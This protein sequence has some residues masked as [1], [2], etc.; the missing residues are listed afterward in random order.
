ME[1]GFFSFLLLF[2]FLSYQKQTAIMNFVECTFFAFLCCEKLFVVN[3][4]VEEI[5]FYFLNT[6]L[7]VLFK[8]LIYNFNS[9][10]KNNV[11]FVY[12]F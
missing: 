12:R 4:E 2:Y 9:F 8:N 1:F 7:T 6:F 5:L 3:F 11:N 10:I